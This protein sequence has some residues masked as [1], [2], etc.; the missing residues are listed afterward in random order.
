MTDSRLYR[1][2]ID[3]R[4]TKVRRIATIVLM[5]AIVSLIGH[6]L[7]SCETSRQPR[8]TGEA[9]TVGPTEMAILDVGPGRTYTYLND[10]KASAGVGDVIELYGGNCLSGPLVWDIAST[11]IRA[12]ATYEASL[13]SFDTSKAYLE[14][15]AAGDYVLTIA[16]SGVRI[17]HIGIRGTAATCY[18]GIG[19]SGTGVGVTIDSVRIEDASGTS[20]FYGVLT[21][22]SGNGDIKIFNSVF[23][24][25]GSFAA[26]RIQNTHTFDI[27]N[28]RFISLG[29]STGGIAHPSFDGGPTGNFHNNYIHIA[30]ATVTKATDV[31]SATITASHNAT[32]KAD[33]GDVGGASNLLNRV[34][35]TELVDA[36]GGD[37]TAA[38]GSTLRVSGVGTDVSGLGLVED[39]H[40]VL[41]SSGWT[42][43][44]ESIAATPEPEAD[45][46]GNSVE[47]TDGDV[48]PSS[49]DHTDF[50]TIG[51]HQTTSRTFTIQNSGTGTLTISGVAI[52]GTH[53]AL[54]TVTDPP[55]L[56][57][58]AAGSD[59]FVVTFNPALATGTKTATVTITSD[60]LD[61]G[62]YDFAISAVSEG[63][64]WVKGGAG[65]VE[66]ISGDT[67]PDAS[68]DTDFGSIVL[69]D[70]KV[71]RKFTV[72]NN[73]GAEI[74]GFVARADSP[75]F[76]IKRPYYTTSLA[77]GASATVQVDFD[78]SSAG[79]HTAFVLFIWNETSTAFTFYVEGTATTETVN[80]SDARVTGFGVEIVDGDTT[81][82]FVDG[83]DFGNVETSTTKDVTFT[84]YNDGGATLSSVSLS[85]ATGTKFTVQTAPASSVSAGAST[86]FVIRYSPTAVE[87]NTDTVT[88][89]SNDPA[90][91]Y[92]FAL[93]GDGIAAL[94]GGEH[95]HPIYD[96]YTGIT[97]G[98]ANTGPIIIEIPAE[99][100]VEAHNNMPPYVVMRWAI[101]AKA[102]SGGIKRAVV[103]DLLATGP[104]VH[105]Y[106]ET[107]TSVGGSIDCTVKG[108]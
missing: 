39:W 108:Y 41:Y 59:T 67:T 50:G 51:S 61:E 8:D 7:A 34:L 72:T 95:T 6:T 58:A 14:A 49:S 70:P 5:V 27:A 23:V 78:P 63:R 26:L 54:F 10:A 1:A 52:S 66:I 12:A 85:L 11:T 83:T 64:V 2:S 69:G 44:N 103:A 107:G 24:G 65:D 87:N 106:D 89:T 42:I 100:A 4:L 9:Q 92:T 15:S 97:L 3:E 20:Y 102:G 22:A 96:D 40:E 71:T 84:L 55:A 68:D 38:G 104:L 17:E 35:A 28:N 101:K 86:T 62:T 19:T 13:T 31:G 77:D 105:V 91:D 80:Y 47:I 79:T 25:H 18:G 16:T 36:A 43:G 32:N 81:P 30:D 98:A 53:A 76:I 46:Y 75:E 57:I 21:D 82:T 45:I 37:V 88:I 90:G 73:T 60:D 99:D 29:T 74:T 56:T 33:I 94:S 48:T 93:S